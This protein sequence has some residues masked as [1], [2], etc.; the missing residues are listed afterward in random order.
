MRCDVI[1]CNACVSI[2]ATGARANAPKVVLLFTDGMDNV[3]T[4]ETIPENV[5]LKNTAGNTLV[6]TFS[7]GAD[8]FIDFTKV[9]MLAS[10]PAWRHVFS[11]TKFGWVSNLTSGVVGSSCNGRRRYVFCVPEQRS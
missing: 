11:T 5:L 10:P 1:Q 6:I 7:V 4:E 3:E 9:R 2:Q 8:G